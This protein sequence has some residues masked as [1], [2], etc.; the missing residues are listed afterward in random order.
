MLGNSGSRMALQYRIL[1][2]LSFALFV[3]EHKRGNTKW[4]AARGVQY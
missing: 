1:S 4:F 2:D 3:A